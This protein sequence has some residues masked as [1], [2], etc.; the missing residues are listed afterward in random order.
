MLHNVIDE[1]HKLVVSEFC[2][3]A[4]HLPISLQLIVSNPTSSYGHPYFE[5]LLHFEVCTLNYCMLH[6]RQG[7]LFFLWHKIFYKPSPERDLSLGVSVG[8]TT[9]IGLCLILVLKLTVWKTNFTKTRYKSPVLVSPDR[10]GIPI[11]ETNP[12]ILHLCYR[13]A[14]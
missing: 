14:S 2:P 5:N 9:E 8:G 11:S 4:C 1:N 10:W 3:R 7:S 13:A 6:I 12:L